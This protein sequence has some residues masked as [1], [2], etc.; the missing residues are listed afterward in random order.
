MKTLLVLLLALMSA[1]AYPADPTYPN[2]P[3]RIVVP[4]PPG[5][6]SDLIARLLATKLP[7]AVGQ[8]GVVDN[9]PGAGSL[10]GTKLVAGSPNDGYTVLLADTPFAVNQEIY[11][12]AGY[13]PLK[14]FTMVTQLATTP[15]LLVVSPSLPVQN[16]REFV[17]LAKAQPG[18]L[19]MSNGG[20]GSIGQLAAAVLMINS[21]IELTGVQYKGGG[22][23]L[24]GLMAS[25]V[26]SN[27][28]PAPVAMPHIKSGKVRALGV[29][30]AKR[31]G[32][33]P[34]VPTMQEGGVKF[35]V[36]NWYIMAAPANTPPAILAKLNDAFAKILSQRDSIDHLAR[37]LIEVAPSSSPRE[38]QDMVSS[39]TARWSRV[40]KQAGI[41]VE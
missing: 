38:V 9:R 18:K 22:P 13:H 25:E 14:N 2:R 21:G 7:D 28:A 30:S 20:V 12:N 41:K 29:T 4:F 16:A 35:L 6:G 11:S 3:I 1:S 40:V 27:V 19:T 31:S 17:A 37:A 8:N 24:I 33:A 23:A 34:D 26:V 15:M 10:I 32:F 5:G 36:T 39:E